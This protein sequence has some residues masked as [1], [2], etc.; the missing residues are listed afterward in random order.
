M[1]E[2]PCVHNF[3]RWIKTTLN[4]SHKIC[5]FRAV[6]MFAIVGTQENILCVISRYYF[7]VL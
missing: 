2:I 5:K 1:S 4:L 7:Y 6:D 3:R